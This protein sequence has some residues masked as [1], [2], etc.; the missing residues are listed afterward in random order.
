MPSYRAG[1][2]RGEAIR[3]EGLSSLQRA[4]KRAGDGGGK[5]LR[6]ELKSI[7]SEVRDVAKIDAPRGDGRSGTPGRLRDSIRSG[8]TQTTASVYSNL[9]YARVQDRGGRVGRHHATILSRGSVSGY[10]TKAVLAE[11]VRVDRHLE[12]IRRQIQ[13]QFEE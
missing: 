12:S 1:A 13:R 6:N 8:A 4:L 11:S 9:V 10:L 7:A 5:I 2:D 3:V